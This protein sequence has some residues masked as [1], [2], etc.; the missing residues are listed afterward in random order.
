M[1]D[2]LGCYSCQTIIEVPD[3][4]VKQIKECVA[5]KEKEGRVPYLTINLLG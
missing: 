4:V 5:E 1:K 3:S 2:A